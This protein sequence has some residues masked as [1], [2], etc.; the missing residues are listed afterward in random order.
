MEERSSGF[1]YI[2]ILV[3]SPKK[4]NQDISKIKYLVNNLKV[5]GGC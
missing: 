1:T 4:N 2:N 3:D 5:Q